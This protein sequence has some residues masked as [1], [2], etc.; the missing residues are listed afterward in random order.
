MYHS[1]VLIISYLI[2]VPDKKKLLT[3]IFLGTGTSGGVPML[4]CDCAVCI[5]GDSRDKRLRSSLLISH[6]GYNILI[7][8]GPDFRCQMLRHGIK[9]LDAILLTHEHRDHTAG[10][11]DIR[12]YNYFQKGALP[13]YCTEEVENSVRDQFAYAFKEPRLSGLPEICFH[14]IS[15]ISFQVG[16][17]SFLPIQVMHHKMPVTGFRMGDFTYIT[18]AN[19]ISAHE[20]E[21]IKGSKIFVLNALRQLPHFSHYNLEEAIALAKE[22]NASTTYFTHLSH[23]MGLHAHIEAALPSSI[24]LAYDGL[25]L[26]DPLVRV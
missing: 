21:K 6:Q 4:G 23:Q 14:R 25:A 9:K 16:G 12:A 22:V 7:D 13:V 19:Y 1:S 17:L 8:A 24:R 26:H 11:D 10:L 15:A 5:S 3:I 18:D 20:I 2:F